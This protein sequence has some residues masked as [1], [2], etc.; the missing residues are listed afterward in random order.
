MKRYISFFCCMAILAGMAACSQQSAPPSASEPVQSAADSSQDF[1]QEDLDSAN[2]PDAADSAA[3]ST[4]PSAS[5]VPENAF[6][7]GN[8]L[9]RYDT[10]E[11][12]QAAVGFAFSTPEYLPAGYAFES[13]GII[14][15]DVAQITYTDGSTSLSFRASLY[16]SDEQ[17]SGLQPGQSIP[18]DIVINNVDVIIYNS[19][20]S[21]RIDDAAAATWSYGNVNYSISAYPYISFDEICDIVS[22]CVA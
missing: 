19:L 11:E 17:L 14:D 8:P 16:L 12:V 9:V 4:V 18:Q 5:G 22:G 7:I 1:T 2:P 15:D 20:I 21:S 13:A 10:I 3:S 6:L